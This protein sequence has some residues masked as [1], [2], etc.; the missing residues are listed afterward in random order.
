MHVHKGDD[1]SHMKDA[2]IASEGRELVKGSR[3]EVIGPHEKRQETMS[4]R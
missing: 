4:P 3:G 1:V 2:Q